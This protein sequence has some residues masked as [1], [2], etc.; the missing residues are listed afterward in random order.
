[1]MTLTAFF[2]TLGDAVALSL[3]VGLF[4]DMLSE[5]TEVIFDWSKFQTNV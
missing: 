1:M 3:P 4:V 5:G 2:L